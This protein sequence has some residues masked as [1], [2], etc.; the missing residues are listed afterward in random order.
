MNSIAA[1]VLASA[2]GGWFRSLTGAWIGWLREPLG[3]SWFPVFQHF[4]SFCCAW[5]VLLWLWQRR[6][7]FK[8]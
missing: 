5:L 3:L 2:F 4:L 8:V 6:I 7:F 1:Y